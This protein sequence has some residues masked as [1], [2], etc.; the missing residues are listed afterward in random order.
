MSMQF[1]AIFLQYTSHFSYLVRVCRVEL[2]LLVTLKL[3]FQQIEKLE[4]TS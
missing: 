4:V 3:S 1:I 2:F